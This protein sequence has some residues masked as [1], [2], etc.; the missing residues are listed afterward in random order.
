MIHS[1]VAHHLT[2]TL[3]KLDLVP[4]FSG[5]NGLSQQQVSDVVQN[6][7]PN[8]TCRSR[9]SPLFRF[10]EGWHFRLKVRENQRRI[11]G[12][13]WRLPRSGGHNKNR[14]STAK[15]WLRLDFNGSLMIQA[16]VIMASGDTTMAGNLAVDKSAIK[17]ELEKPYDWEI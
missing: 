5:R 9:E 14:L 13:A 1:Y 7:C 10:R 2:M 3:T 11:P 15:I 6:P 17:M 4:R 12:T 8:Q 16:P